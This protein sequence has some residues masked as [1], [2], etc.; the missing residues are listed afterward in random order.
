MSTW[1]D[2]RRLLAEMDWPEAKEWRSLIRVTQEDGRAI[3]WLNEW[4]KKKGRVVRVPPTVIK[5]GNREYLLADWARVVVGEELSNVDWSGMES[6]RSTLREEL[7][8]DRDPMAR[9][10][11]GWLSG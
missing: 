6:D 2:A 3:D 11:L 8:Q 5:R 7:K 1:S 9:A 10:W 4:G